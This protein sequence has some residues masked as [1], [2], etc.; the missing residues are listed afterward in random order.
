MG[1][2]NTHSKWLPAKRAPETNVGLSSL[3]RA[4]RATTDLELELLKNRLLREQ[5]K[6]GATASAFPALV[7]AAN[8][9]AALVWLTPYPL[10]FLPSLLEE[11]AD[12]AIKHVAQ[13]AVIRR[14]SQALLGAAA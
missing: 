2:Q 12:I 9:A 4:K 10:L 13:Q 6:K 3:H 8:E 7:R 11:K 1:V 14:R 5:V